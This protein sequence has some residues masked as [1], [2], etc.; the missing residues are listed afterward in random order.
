MGA[1]QL[2]R[3][4]APDDG[5]ERQ[6]ASSA[7]TETGSRRERPAG[8]Q[9]DAPGVGDQQARDPDN[10]DREQ[11]DT[12][13][14]TRDE[15]AD[16]VR[17]QGWGEA[18]DD[19]PDQDESASSVDEP[20]EDTAE[21]ELAEP[22]TRDEY[23]DDMRGD[24]DDIDPVP[25]AADDGQEAFGSP[26]EGNFEEPDVE[27]AE[28]LSR[29][30]Y[31]DSMR[32]GGD[33]LAADTGRP[34]TGLSGDDTPSD[35]PETDRTSS[36]TGAEPLDNPRAAE[37]APEAADNYAGDDEAGQTREPGSASADQPPSQEDR[38]RWQAE[39]QEYLR[40]AKSDKDAAGGWDQ[41]ANVVGDKPDRSPGDASDLPPAGEQLLS[42][43]EG[44]LSRF[45]ALRR[46][47][48]K[49]EVLDGLHG[50]LEHGADAI[51]KWLGQRLP[52]GHAEQPVPASP[53][54][55]PEGHHAEVSAGSVAAM[56]LVLAV[57]GIEAGRLVH[58]KLD[59]L[60]GD[61]HGGN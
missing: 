18:P 21:G 55:S 8:K 50:D 39:Y 34:D 49:E 28:P 42:M 46:E 48:E 19:H 16:D 57:M 52:V 6:A 29:E 45:E 26:A 59:T 3:S 44:R 31:A 33:P 11:R 43:E 47:S 30:G 14:Q 61:D 35:T 32:A 25:Q 51:Q 56:G 23:A 41:G 38:D 58:R 1:D 15:Y 27:E 37:D 5:E 13:E 53:Q 10:N 60:R 12:K 22:L 2:G 9:P 24:S 7:S 17:S 36:E 4:D 54:R 40:D 20:R